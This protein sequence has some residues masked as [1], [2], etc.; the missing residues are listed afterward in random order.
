M[1][2]LCRGRQTRPLVLRLAKPGWLAL[3]S[4]D[5]ANGGARALIG[6]LNGAAVRS[7]CCDRN[8]STRQRIG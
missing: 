5:Q 7:R 1:R 3:D 8:L 4:R 6:I 2:I